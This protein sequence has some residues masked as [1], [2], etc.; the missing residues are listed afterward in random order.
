[1][2]NVLTP[3]SSLKAGAFIVKPFLVKLNADVFRLVMDGIMIV[4]G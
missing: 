1:L 2:F 4:A 3:G